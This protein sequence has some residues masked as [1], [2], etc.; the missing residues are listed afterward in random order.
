MGGLVGGLGQ[1][2]GYKALMALCQQQGATQASPW[3]T[4]TT[5]GTNS[6]AFQQAVVTPLL[7]SQPLDG[8]PADT[9]EVRWLKKRIREIEWRP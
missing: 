8:H 2:D 7:P 5:T 4:T 6:I 3:T 1:Q 9:E